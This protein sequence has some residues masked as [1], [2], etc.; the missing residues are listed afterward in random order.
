MGRGEAS[1]DCLDLAQPGAVGRILDLP[2]ERGVERRVDQDHAHAMRPQQREQPIDRSHG[3]GVNLRRMVPARLD[4]ERYLASRPFGR[5]QLAV[6]IGPLDR[7]VGEQHIHGRERPGAGRARQALRRQPPERIVNRRRQRQ[8][9]GPAAHRPGLEPGVAGN[10]ETGGHGVVVWQ[11]GKPERVGAAVDRLEGHVPDADDHGLGQSAVA[12]QHLDH[13]EKI[14]VVVPVDVGVVESALRQKL[15]V[16]F[17]PL[18]GA[19]QHDVRRGVETSDVLT[20]QLPR[21]QI[22]VE[23]RIIT[24]AGQGLG[25]PSNSRSAVGERGKA[26]V[27]S[28]E[29]A[30]QQ[31]R[32]KQGGNQVEDRRAPGRIN[33]LRGRVFPQADPEQWSE[34][35][36]K[37]P[38]SIGLP[39][40]RPDTADRCAVVT[41]V[42]SLL[43]VV[44]QGACARF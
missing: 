29:G 3:P 21:V 11:C 33:D 34:P 24:A 41:V 39:S 44:E 37:P 4:G 42:A 20:A 19:E 35:L 36:A 28:R 9:A 25:D 43:A 7:T 6:I 1:G 22:E 10:A 27:R 2:I 40:H 18:A 13:G 23:D 16:R 12:K 30:H 14:L 38:G 5:E 15:G 26:V 31:D 17:L 8:K 32:Q